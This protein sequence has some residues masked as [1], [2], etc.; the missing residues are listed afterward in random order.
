[1]RRSQVSYEFV[2]GIPDEL[3]EGVVYISIS[4]AS[5]VHR[6]L[7]GCGG[8][9]TTPLDPSQW[10]LAFD[11]QSITLNP[12]I[13]NWKLD[14]RSNYKIK[15]SRVRWLLSWSQVDVEVGRGY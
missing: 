5:A 8:K 6:C 2:D 1:M 15:R 7:C 13:D 3:A 10:K 4:T 9:V 11:G 12:A 14:C